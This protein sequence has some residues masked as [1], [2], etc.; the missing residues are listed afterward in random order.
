MY[1]C[2][3]LEPGILPGY[4]AIPALGYCLK[5]P[6]KPIG[7]LS[8]LPKH[9]RG[10]GYTIWERTLIRIGTDVRSE[11]LTYRWPWHAKFAYLFLALGMISIPHVRNA[12]VLDTTLIPS[13]SSP[14][15]GVLVWKRP[16]FSRAV[17]LCLDGTKEPIHALC[18]S[19]DGISKKEALRDDMFFTVY[20]R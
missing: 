15:T 3:T 13:A 10:F 8:T 9:Y 16:V 7:T 5:Y 18:F 20:A 17:C 1:V 11:Y 12:P 14:M 19:N 6:C 2:T 4:V